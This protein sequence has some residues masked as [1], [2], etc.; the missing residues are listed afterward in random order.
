MLGKRVNKLPKSK[1]PLL[2]FNPRNQKQPKTLALHQLC[3]LLHPNRWLI[4]IPPLVYPWNTNLQLRSIQTGLLLPF[5]LLQKV[6][7]SRKMIGKSSIIRACSIDFLRSL[8]PRRIKFHFC[9]MVPGGGLE[10]P[11][12]GLWVRRSNRLSYPGTN[13]IYHVYLLTLVNDKHG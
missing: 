4:K 7:M 6:Q 13:V 3:N 12:F 8:L 11:T 9:Y 5:H 10:P 2:I 1:N